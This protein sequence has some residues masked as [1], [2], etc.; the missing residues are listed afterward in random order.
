MDAARTAELSMPGRTAVPSIEK[1]FLPGL[2]KR[3]SVKLLS[4]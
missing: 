1:N 2:R 3:L 4:A